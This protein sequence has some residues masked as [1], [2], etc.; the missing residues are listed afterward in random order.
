MQ[1]ALFHE[2]VAKIDGVY[3]IVKENTLIHASYS[4]NLYEHRIMAVIT[5]LMR[6]TDT[7]DTVYH[8]RVKDFAEYFGLNA[9][10]YS[11]LKDVFVQ[12]R[13]KTFVL[14]RPGD[15]KRI[16]GWISWAEIIPST[17]VVQVAIDDKIR[18]YFLEIK[19]K[20]GYTKY[21]LKNVRGFQCP[22]AYR[23]YERFKEELRG[24]HK[25]KKLYMT[26][27]EIKD[28][29]KLNDQYQQF[30]DLRK[31]VLIPSLEDIN[32]YCSP[33]GESKR[34]KR[35]KNLHNEGSDIEVIME[36]KRI[37]RK[38]VG[39]EFHITRRDIAE[40]ESDQDVDLSPLSKINTIESSPSN[41]VALTTD[42]SKMIT[43]FL[44]VGITQ[45]T[46]D[47]SIAKYGLT[48][49]IYM[50][51][52][53]KKN[54]NPDDPAAYGAAILQNG[55]GIPKNEYENSIADKEELY[56]DAL[57]ANEE[58]IIA[59]SEAAATLT[60]SR[61]EEIKTYIESLSRDDLQNIVNECQDMLRKK[62]IRK[63]TF[64]VDMIDE[65]PHRFYIYDYVYRVKLN[66][67]D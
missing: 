40:N 7:K 25:T 56:R 32:G 62:G 64:T 50:Y 35:K 4:L 66:K 57:K 8:F 27:E 2:D 48:N 39:V 20:L 34:K 10:I 61:D 11:T 45:N 60:K 22:Y 29:F 15:A 18:P 38:F 19:E 17:G 23:F 26:V 16:T 5:S 1:T 6:P 24:K 30:S 63:E 46:I 54:K 36:P 12:L 3:S 52:C 51:R 65:V 21:A 31:R 41:Y 43:E 59:Q 9:D 53:Y 49:L 58:M 37:G 44:S 47:N 14:Q 67:E 28:W 55:W 42:Q 13:S 33:E